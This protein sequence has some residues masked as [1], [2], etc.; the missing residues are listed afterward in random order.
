MSSSPAGGDASEA[1]SRVYKFLSATYQ[2]KE[3]QE[4]VLRVNAA[5]NEIELSQWTGKKK[6]VETVI[7]K[8][9]LEPNADV[10]VDGALLRVSELSVTLESPGAAGEVADLLRRPARELEAVKLVTDAEASVSGF[11]EAREEAL[12]LL[13]RI[14]VD[15]RGALFAV[16]STSAADVADPLDAVYSTLSSRLA[17]SLEKTK[18]FLAGGE[19]SL[20][21][22]TDRLCAIAYTVGAVQN[23]LFEGDSDL[24]QELDALQELGIASTAQELRME[25]PTARLM[26][27]AHPTLVALATSGL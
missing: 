16:D 25:R 20:G 24:A 15:P 7:A 17:E 8:F 3:H 12:N 18:S 13:S 5:G 22:A 23:A 19:K 1:P 21:S 14:K 10:Q 9:R 2:N 6:R 4:G 11:L 26:L 27:K